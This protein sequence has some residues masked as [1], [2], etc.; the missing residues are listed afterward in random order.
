MWFAQVGL[1]TH[2]VAPG[3]QRTINSAATRSAPVPPGAC[4]VRTRLAN[5]AWCSPNYWFS[6]FWQ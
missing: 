4:A 5:N 2:T 3:L 1:V 6:I